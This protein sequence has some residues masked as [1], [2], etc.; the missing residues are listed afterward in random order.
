[1]IQL[2]S[3]LLP[4]KEICNVSGLYYHRNE[5]RIDF[6]GYFNLF[7][8][9]KRKK[10]TTIDNLSLSI[11]L[12]G[13]KEIILVHDHNDLHR[14][15][16]VS[17][18]M[19]KYSFHFPYKQTE[20]GMFWF[21]LVED[22]AVRCR[23]MEGFFVTE[24]NGFACRKVNIGIDICTYKREIYVERNL[25]QLSDK[26]LKNA[27]L[28]VSSHLRIYVID[29]GRTL[30]GFR[31]IQEISASS[32]RK[33]QIYNNKNAGGAGGFTRGMLEILKDKE[34]FELTHVLLMDDDAVMEPDSLVR[35]YGLLSTIKE[36]WQDAAVGGG[37]F[38]ED[39]P[40]ILFTAGE[41]WEKGSI[42]T[43]SP[44][45][46]MQLYENCT[47]D[48]IKNG[49]NE[50]KYY[51]GWWCCCYPLTV[52][53]ERNLPLPLF[54]HRD[55]IEYGIRNRDNG[56]IYINGIDVW[57]RGFEMT[58]PRTNLYYDVRN[59]LVLIA[60][61]CGEEADKIVQKYIFRM[62]T[63]SI[64]RLKYK[65]CEVVYQALL[66]FLKGPEWLLEKE[67][68]A[69]LTEINAISYQL[70]E[71]KD[72]QGLLKTEEYEIVSSQIEAYC[73][74]F[75]PEV[76]RK[77]YVERGRIPKIKYLTYNG[78]LLPADKTKIT[79]VPVL[80]SS[81]A[82][83]RKKKIVIFEPYT[84]KYIIAEKKYRELWKGIC[85]NF[86]AYIVSKRKFA[87]A[88]KLFVENKGR[89]SDAA[90]WRKYLGIDD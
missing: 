89:L 30:Q 16:L 9:D 47:C 28:D 52:V 55:D 68:E 65:E 29:N 36:E 43:P 32:G 27:E 72:L 13:F 5:S 75:S 85:L 76:L 17:T 83:Y 70:S 33:I 37:V 82:T 74:S 73:E 40:E 22:E 51:S 63:A 90:V 53:T 61:Y 62:I 1:M 44:L 80:E 31:D 58:M 34:E 38:R 26:L 57:H 45:L 78:W 88:Q 64:G 46:D 19:R 6:N 3:V 25:S 86:K 7:Y 87:L 41:W 81:F 84:R 39:F 2:Q 35:L 42:V 18:E 15:D 69:L 59:N 21:A 4:T 49:M 66:D 14:E 54:I 12:K 11:Q 67:P 50:H 56:I 23:S 77:S 10:Y 79:A 60:L 71:Y 24:K 20:S 48:Y 8:I